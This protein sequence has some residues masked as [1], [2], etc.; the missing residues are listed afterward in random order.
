[1]ADGKV[2]FAATSGIDETKI[3]RT[4]EEAL[5]V[6]KFRPVD[7][8]FKHFANPISKTSKDGI[9]DDAVLEFSNADALQEVNNLSKIA[10]ES[11]KRIKSIWRNRCTERSFCSGQLKKSLWLLQRSIHRRKCLLHRNRPRKAKNRHGASEF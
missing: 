5:S 2:G 1:M 7:P 9:I 4:I 11:D 6:A 8:K 3:E 10:F